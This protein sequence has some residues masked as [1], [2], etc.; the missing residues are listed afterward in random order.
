MVK[1]IPTIPYK[2]T[3]ITKHGYRFIPD[4]LDDADDFV[5]V[6][7]PE[8]FVYKIN[9]SMRIRCGAAGT[10]ETTGSSTTLYYDEKEE[11]IPGIYKLIKNLPKNIKNELSRRITLKLK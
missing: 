3:Y 5:L 10:G 6:I 1:I 11:N 2:N 7:T 9:E 8:D 4:L